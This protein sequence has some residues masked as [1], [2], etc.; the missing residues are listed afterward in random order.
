VHR[1]GA[2]CNACWQKN[3]DRS[4]VYVAGLAQR[5]DEPPEWLGDFA[6]YAAARFC[7]ARAVGLLADLGGLLADGV[8]R[9]AAL[10]E[11]AR[12]TGSSIGPL[13][14]TL[15]GFFVAR[16]LALPLNHAEDLETRRRTRRIE[17]TPEPFRP[18]VAAFAD[19]QIGHGHTRRSTSPCA[20]SATSRA[21]W[22]SATRRSP[23][24]R[25]STSTTSRR[26]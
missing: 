2:Q 16:R 20:P 12:W 23:A 11:Q 15:E 26:S 4:F 25:P 18:A 13:A 17:Q 14:R 21:S 8:T 6:A 1:D 10:L 9:P 7:P 3:P 22:P 24:G 19:A 5:L